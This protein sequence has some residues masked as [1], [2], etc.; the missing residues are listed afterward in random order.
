[1]PHSCSPSRWSLPATAR[2]CWHTGAVVFSTVTDRPTRRRSRRQKSRETPEGGLYAVRDGHLNQLTEDPTDS[3]PDFSAD[4]RKIAFVRGGDVWAMRADGSGQRQLTSGA[5]ARQPAAVSPKASYVV[6]ERRA[7]AGG[8]ARP[9]HGQVRR[10]RPHRSSPAPATSTKRRSRPTARR[11][12]SS[13]ASPRPAAAPPTTSTRCGPRAPAWPAS[14]G[15]ATS[16]SSRPA[17]SSAAIVF[18]RGESSEGPGAYAD[19]FTMRSNGT[20]VEGAGRRRRLV[21]RRRRRRRR[22]HAALPPR[23]GPLGEEDRPGTGPQAEPSF[24]TS[25]ATNSVFSSDGRK[26]AAF[27][28]TDEAETLSAIDVASRPQLAARRRLR[29]GKRLDRDDDRVGDGLAAGAALRTPPGSSSKGPL[30]RERALRRFA[31]V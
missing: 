23:P 11:S 17:T 18:S 6:F 10:Q 13:A 4:G 26:V 14:P 2:R 30:L 24:P 8:S 3:E 21:L 31:A 22:P 29:A 19:I 25:S 7:T 12:S 15:P 9:L 16:T 5:E 20:K 27:I 28:A 1:M